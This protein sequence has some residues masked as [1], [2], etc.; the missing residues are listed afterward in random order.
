M[1]KN[2]A[3]QRTRT[4]QLAQVCAHFAAWLLLMTSTPLLAQASDASIGLTLS[5]AP[6]DK[7]MAFSFQDVPVRALLQVLGET[8]GVNIVA[9]ESVTGTM[10]LN[11]KDA[12]WQEALAVIV[13]AKNLTVEKSNNTYFV[14]GDSVMLSEQ[15][16]DDGTNSYG[17]QNYGRVDTIV[18]QYQKAESVRKMIVESQRLLSPHGAVMAD[19]LSNQ[20]L[21]QDTPDRVAQIRGLIKRIDQPARQVLIEAR[22]VEADDSFSRS[23]GMKLSFNDL[24]SS[25]FQSVPNPTNPSQNIQIP[26]RS[27]GNSTYF[28]SN[29]SFG[30]AIASAAV[31]PA[32]YAVSVFRK[33]LSQ[34]INLEISALEVDGLG[35]V[36]SSPRVVTSNN[37]KALIEQGT[38]IPY[39]ESTSSGATSTSFRKA[40]L[41]LE[42][43]PQ[44]TP[45]GDVIM[46]VDVA[47]DS[48]GS[49]VTD[50]GY[51]INTKHVQTQVK[52]ENGGTLVI[53][54]IYQEASN[55]SENKVPL[56]GDIPLLGYLF[57]RT[58]KSVSK[59]ELLIFLTPYVLDAKG[60][61][62]ALSNLHSSESP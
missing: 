57:K 41:K 55:N 34:F 49:L 6:T 28:G 27:Q 11:L 43:T 30:A 5:A 47:K 9:N 32:T 33:G 59:T 56:L 37:V 22:I 45:N 19:P 13:K 53:G 52:V 10:T 4:H 62:T 35:K 26:T 25:G 20:L 48:I 54:G 12:S 7:R 51:T 42:V 46:D 31:D 40:N 17:I 23:L 60:K 8:A 14:T 61:P 39:Q 1:N 38:E 36:I 21:V 16:Y 2:Q 58:D 24:T 15:G 44:I 18:L 3:T 50:A 29:Q